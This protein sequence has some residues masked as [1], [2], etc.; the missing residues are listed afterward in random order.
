MTFVSTSGGT[1]WDIH[2]SI[3]TAESELFASV[4]AYDRRGSYSGI[5]PCDHLAGLVRD[6]SAP[7]RFKL[8]GVSDW[9]FESFLWGVKPKLGREIP[10]ERLCPLLVLAS[11][12][13][14]TDLR[15]YAM[16]KISLHEMD[17]IRKIVLAR[18]TN[19]PGWLRVPY[20][21]LAVRIF[22]LNKSE[23]ETL[24]LE[25]ATAITR[26][27][28]KVLRRR[29]GLL[30]GSEPVAWMGGLFWHSACWEVLTGALMS[31]LDESKYWTMSPK[32]AVMAA[33]AEMQKEVP[34]KVSKKLCKTCNDEAKIAMW[35]DMPGDWNAA[36]VILQEH[37][38]KNP[39]SWILK[40]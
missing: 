20:I 32:Q 24:G 14:F 7:H 27:R 29:L 31:A 33:L 11:D 4:F 12:W 13:G 9:D 18:R 34:G 16:Q 6:R 28:E 36:E 40:K 19:V 21:S 1:T 10:L 17:P 38:G 35:L 2:S 15:R 5:D 25:T 39:D 30:R 3:F 37:L 8:S 23:V 22:P 26:A